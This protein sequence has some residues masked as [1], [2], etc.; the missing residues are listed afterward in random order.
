MDTIYSLSLELIDSHQEKVLKFSSS[1]SF[2]ASTAAFQVEGAWNISGK[3]PSI[4]DTLTHAH[5]ELIAD[6]SNADSG[7]DSYHLYLQDIEALKI[8]GFQHYRFSISWSRLLPDG[9]SN[10][11]QDAVDYYNE[12]IEELILND[13]EPVVTMYHYG[14]F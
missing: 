10:L 14:E 8:V 6:H 7:P 3:G 9:I 5:P 13:I 12:L 4:W 11:N 1:F 2:G